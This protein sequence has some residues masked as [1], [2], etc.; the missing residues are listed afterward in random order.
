MRNLMIIALTTAATAGS[1]A[2]GGCMS[3]PHSKETDRAFGDAFG[4]AFSSALTN[5]I[6][7]SLNGLRDLTYAAEAFRR[8][9][10][11]WPEDYGELRL[12]V[13]RSDGYLVLGE[14]SSVDLTNLPVDRLQIGFVPEG[15]TNRS[16]LTLEPRPVK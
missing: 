8:K 7:P 6:A 5:S 1:L 12:F 2:L 3:M 9:N 16:T 10:A 15:Q 13:E 14:Y 11:R 4:E